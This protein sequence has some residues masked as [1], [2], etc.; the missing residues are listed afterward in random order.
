MELKGNY[1]IE[2]IEKIGEGA[3]GYVEKI[4]LYTLSHKKCG[5]YARKVFNPIDDITRSV[6]ID[7]LKKRFRREILCQANCTHKNIVPIYLFDCDVEKPY[8]VM[9]LAEMDIAEE[10]KKNQLNF[11]EKL[12]LS[13]SVLQGINRI[14]KGNYLHRDI[15]PNNVLKFKCGNYKISDFGL[16]KNTESNDKSTVLT[17]IGEVMG[18]TTFIAPEILMGCDYSAQ[19]DIFAIGKLMEGL[20]VDNKHYKLITDKCCHMD[21]QQRYDSIDDIIIDMAKITA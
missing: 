20:D 15:K 1:L 9:D 10:I 21:S 12:Y 11:S 19:S 3:F 14:H 5:E 7:N 13:L 16:V 18:T 6:S 17:K 8:F 4:N 2:P